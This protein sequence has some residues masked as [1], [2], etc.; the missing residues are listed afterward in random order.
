[1]S[2]YSLQLSLHS[3]SPAEHGDNMLPL[4]TLYDK[5]PSVFPRPRGK[6]PGMGTPWDRFGFSLTGPGLYTALNKFGHK[7]HRLFPRSQ[8][9]ISAM[10]M[11]WYEGF[12]VIEIQGRMPD[13]MGAALDSFHEISYRSCMICGADGGTVLRGRGITARRSSTESAEY[14]RTTS[15]P[16]RFVLCPPH[17]SDHALGWDWMVSPRGR[18]EWMN[19]YGDQWEPPPTPAQDAST[20][21]VANMAARRF[22]F[23]V[24]VASSPVSWVVVDI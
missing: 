12:A 5:Y 7:T 3:D 13:D 14:H 16:L 22:V 9:K 15:N 1:M 6:G 20:I 4:E 21:T 17:G 18:Y 23:R 19:P 24:A 8:A 11:S 10:Y 2:W